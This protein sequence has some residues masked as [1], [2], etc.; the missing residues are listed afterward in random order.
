M[1]WSQEHLAAHAG[2]EMIDGEYVN[3]GIGLPLLIPFHLPEGSRWCST[4]T[5]ASLAPTRRRSMSIP[6]AFRVE[7]DVHLRIWLGGRSFDYRATYAA[8]QSFI[9]EWRRV[10]EETIE[11]V[12]QSIGDLSLLPRLPC[13][14]LFN[15]A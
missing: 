7:G 9:R 6:A 14:R 4:A 11:L 8:A 3:L 1:S 15:S 2:A 12:L 10:R 13:E 5:T